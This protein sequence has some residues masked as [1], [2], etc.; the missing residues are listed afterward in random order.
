MR[1]TRTMLVL[2][3]LAALAAGCVPLAIGAAGAGAGV[4]YARGNLESSFPVAVPEVTAATEAAL[5]QMRMRE[6]TVIGSGIDAELTARTADDDKVTIKL[7]SPGEGVTNISIRIG[8][9]GDRDKSLAIYNNI[10]DELIR[11]G[12]LEP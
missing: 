7:D 8:T 3:L 10:R 6:I 2:A 4:A 5:R 9:F 12:H 11:R 1:S